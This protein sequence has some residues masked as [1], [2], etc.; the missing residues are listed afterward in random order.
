MSSVLTPRPRHPSR[1]RITTA[2]S[3]PRV[4]RRERETETPLGRPVIIFSP[5]HPSSSS[6]PSSR[7]RV[8]SRHPRSTTERHRTIDDARRRSRSRV[9][10]RAR[11][12]I[13][14]SIH[15]S[16][17]SRC[18][19]PVVRLIRPPIVLDGARRDAKTKNENE[20]EST[21]TSP[22]A[23]SPVPRVRMRIRIDRPSSR[24]PFEIDR[25]RSVH[26]HL[27]VYFIIVYD[28]WTRSIYETRLCGENP[29][30][31]MRVIHA[32]VRA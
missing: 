5:S 32:C 28:L 23:R 9:T 19:R 31:R 12:P 13:A 16:Q 8:A 27:L 18:P 30:A 29:N 22:R 17:T 15:P 11:G 3:S 14:S 6:F 4:I 1:P 7:L 2:R 10:V 26:L 24:R 21:R 20:N 25:I